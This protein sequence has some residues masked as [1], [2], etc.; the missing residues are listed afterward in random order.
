[1]LHK[2]KKKWNF[3]ELKCLFVFGFKLYKDYG[4]SRVSFSNFKIAMSVS[5][6]DNE[7]RHAVNQ[8]ILDYAVFVVWNDYVEQGSVDCHSNRELI[9][10][11][12]F[13]TVSQFYQLFLSTWSEF[14]M[15]FIFV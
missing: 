3:P 6:F 2:F 11:N 12:V 5:T 4:V 9:Q 10:C 15:F 1:M 13:F 14:G 8:L 7:K